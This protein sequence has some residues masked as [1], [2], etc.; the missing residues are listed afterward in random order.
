MIVLVYHRV[1]E[2]KS[3]P[4][5]LA[6]TP[7]NFRKQMRYLKESV[8]LV[9]FEEDWTK[10]PKPAI[11]ITFDDGY[12]DNVL[13]ALPILEEVGVPATF[14]ISTG[15]I[16]T[17]NEFWWHELE[18]IILE[19]ENL[20]V[21]FTL[22]DNHFGKTWSITS[23]RERQELY[24]GIVR[25]MNEVDAVRRADW[26]IQLHSWAG[27]ESASATLHR[28]MTIEELRLLA[29]NSLVTIGAH[30]VT[31]TR[32]ASL[33][34]EVQREEIAASKQKLETWLGREVMVFSYPFGRRC[35]YTKES[36][37][38]CREAGF[39]KAA[40]NFPGQVHRWTDPYQI[41]RHLVRNWPVEVFAEKL[42]GFWTR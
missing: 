17:S 14:F 1:T 40:A 15:T 33:S 9:R 6:V 20:P 28:S 37:A 7:D 19:P 8:P 30:T 29:E 22:Y 11:A 31:H 41:P 4:E 36:V 2:L 12:A 13:E 10:A 26:L 27:I 38:L 34:T 32:L 35:E 3:D 25:L 23:D 5:M 18:R 21:S 39:V 16:G 42:R 24:N